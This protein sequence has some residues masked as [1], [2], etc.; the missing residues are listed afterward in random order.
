[1]SRAGRKRKMGERFPSGQIRPEDDGPSPA[2]VK[3]LRGAA[4]LGMADAQWGSIA[5][6][7][8]LSKKIDESEYQAAKRFGD[9]HSQYISVI[10]GPRAPKT[11]TGEI[12]SKGV[13]VDV[14]TELGRQQADKHISVM[15]K[16]NE[17]HTALLMVSPMAENDI[18]RFCSM[19]GEAPSGHEGMMRVKSGLKSLA[20]LW[21]II[22]K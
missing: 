2:A 8:F 6:L 4:L 14:D 16:Y 11:S 12:P 19:P 9:L 13:Q 15:T 22:V 7:Y 17:A 18:I 1:M 20:E 5:G 21:N 10:G 3:R